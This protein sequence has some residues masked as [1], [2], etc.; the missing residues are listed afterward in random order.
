MSVQKDLSP[1]QENALRQLYEEDGMSI[2]K[3]SRHLNISIYVIRE[4]IRKLNLKKLEILVEKKTDY[5]IITDE[6]H[7]FEDEIKTRIFP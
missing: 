5:P 1:E 2:Q 4:N 7:P 6:T 3:I